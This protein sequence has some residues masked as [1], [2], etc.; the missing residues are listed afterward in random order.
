MNINQEIILV[1]EKK[2]CAN[3]GHPTFSRHTYTGRRFL[4]PVMNVRGENQPETQDEIYCCDKWTAGINVVECRLEEPQIP[5]EKA[6]I[7]WTILEEEGIP[8]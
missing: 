5:V 8:R 4:C 1:K 2:R 3:C 7:S 6:R